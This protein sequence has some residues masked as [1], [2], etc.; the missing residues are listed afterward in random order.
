LAELGGADS[1]EKAIETVVDR[2]YD[3]VRA[4]KAVTVREV[5]KA[6]SISEPQTEKLARLLE[7][8]RLVQ[9]NY[10]LSDITITMAE[11]PKEAPASGAGVEADPAGQALLSACDEVARAKSLLEFS[12]RQVEQLSKKLEQAALQQSL[13]PKAKDVGPALRKRLESLEADASQAKAHANAALVAAT[14]LEDAGQK[15]SQVAARKGARQ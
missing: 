15:I 8:S 4:R 9:V 13:A 5:S 7:A 10:T 6:L 2:L 12:R 11:E 3:L 14:V 1:T